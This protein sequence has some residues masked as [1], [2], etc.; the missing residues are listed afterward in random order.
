MP[1]PHTPT[2]A[3]S[4]EVVGAAEQSRAQVWESGSMLNPPEL[5]QVALHLG[6]SV[7]LSENSH[8]RTSL[9]G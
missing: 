8:D 2:R 6:A 5:G 7:S 3:I 9:T 1:S 4:P